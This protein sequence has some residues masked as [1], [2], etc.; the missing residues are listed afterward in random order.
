M[1]HC[2]VHGGC[3]MGRPRFGMNLCMRC[4]AKRSI[5]RPALGRRVKWHQRIG[6]QLEALY[7]GQAGELAAIKLAYHF[8][9]ASD[10]V[11]DVEYPLFAA[12]TA[13]RRFEP[14]TSCLGTVA[15]NTGGRSAARPKSRSAAIG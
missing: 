12:E 11:G 8:E 1:V 4:T 3:A 14:Q 15:Q 13:G 7:A 5:T 6:E 2:L 10:W 9:Q